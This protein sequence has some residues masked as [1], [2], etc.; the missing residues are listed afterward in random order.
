MSVTLVISASLF[1]MISVIRQFH[2]LNT[3]IIVEEIWKAPYGG[4]NKDKIIARRI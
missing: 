2:Q 1:S 4:R 3:S